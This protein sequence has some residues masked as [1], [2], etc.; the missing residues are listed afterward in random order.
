MLEPIPTPATAL[1]E[2]HDLSIKGGA[3]CPGVSEAMAGYDSDYGVLREAIEQN[4][5][6]FIHEDDVA[7]V[8]IYVDTIQAAGT[9]ISDIFTKLEGLLASIGYCPI[10][11]AYF[12]FTTEPPIQS[13]V[14]HDEDCRLAW[15]IESL[16]E[17]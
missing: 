13:V 1:Q 14:K 8:A 17:E 11:G 6:P 3:R 2:I 9:W 15:Y 12:Q 4:L 5:K 10:C 7:E 16:E